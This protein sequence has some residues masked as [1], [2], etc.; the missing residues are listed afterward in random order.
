MPRAVTET[1]DKTSMDAIEVTSQP[2]ATVFVGVSRVKLITA[3]IR[4]TGHLCR[5]CVMEVAWRSR[6]VLRNSLLE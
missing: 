3:R 4:M 6:A 5:R 2:T 1:G